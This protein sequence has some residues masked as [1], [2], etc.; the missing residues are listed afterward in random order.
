MKA[1]PSLIGAVSC[2]IATAL[3]PVSA[4]A[5]V[6]IPGGYELTEAAGYSGVLSVPLRLQEVYGSGMFGGSPILV[7]SIAFRLDANQGPVSL[8]LPSITMSMSTTSKSPDGL[9]VSYAD[10]VGPDS[11]VVYSG[12][13]SVSASGGGS[14]N[15]FDIVV[16]LANPFSYDPSSGNLLIDI[17]NY[18]STGT[19]WVD[20]SNSTSDNASRVFG[21]SVG[22]ATATY[23]DTGADVILIKTQPIPEPAA[24]CFAVA[25]VG[26]A[27]AGVRMVRRQTR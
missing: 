5:G 2:V 9:S 1:R 27:L 6:V 22:S 7:T 17:T 24:S 15:P 25:C 14:P 3:L 23:A 13:L 4:N 16:D 11:T 20:A 8:N 18:S 10:N 19:W 26:I 12:S 21:Y